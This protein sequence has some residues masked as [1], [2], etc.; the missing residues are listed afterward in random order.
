M[1]GGQLNESDIQMISDIE[2][3]YRVSCVVYM[4]CMCIK[5]L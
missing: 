5:F 2:P 4:I 1:G 3:A